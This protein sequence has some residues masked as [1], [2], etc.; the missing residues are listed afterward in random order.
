[1]ATVSCALDVTPTPYGVLTR[2]LGE[3]R[4]YAET[5]DVV[6]VREHPSLIRQKYLRGLYQKAKRLLQRM[7][8][9]K[10][11]RFDMYSARMSALEHTRPLR[12]KRNIL[13]DAL[14]WVTGTA[15]L[16]DIKAVREKVNELMTVRDSERVIIEDTVA[17]VKENRETIDEIT[18]KSNELIDI[19][20]RVQGTLTKL[21][22]ATTRLSINMY[23]DDVALAIEN[24]LSYLEYYKIEQDRF[25][26]MFQYRRDLAIVGHLTEA[27]VNRK[28]IEI[29]L[30]KV[31]TDLT[32][33]YLYENMHVRI[34]NLERQKLGFWVSIPVLSRESY[35]AWDIFAVPFLYRDVGKVRQIVPELSHAGVGLNSGKIITLD[36]CQ[37]GNPSLCPSPVEYGKLECVDGILSK[38]TEKMSKCLMEEVSNYGVRVRRVSSSL[39]LLFTQ[40]ETLEERC[41]L[42][43]VRSKKINPGTYV[44]KANIGCTLASNTGWTFRF[45]STFNDTMQRTDVF[46]LEVSNVDFVLPTMETKV[47]TINVSYIKELAYV[48]HHALP[49]LTKLQTVQMYN[50]S[51]ATIGIT[52]FGLAAA[53][54]VFLSVL[55]Y[56]RNKLVLAKKQT[57]VQLTKVDD[58]KP[59]DSTAVKLLAQV[60][61]IV[62]N[63]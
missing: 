9:I 55:V 38:N 15:T 42:E 35:T 37:Y 48:K 8:Q 56:R 26:Q 4:T 2:R 16:D 57:K 30:D 58:V 41:K 25:D 39:L 6:F 23:A 22:N 10:P 53:V 21:S 17:C 24:I 44:V 60:D 62:K 7:E 54:V 28:D 47:Q 49:D 3:A 29:V 14:R 19:V 12:E 18:G 59:N 11:N 13:G 43:P 46:P 50:V 34:M 20:N 63:P 45:L 32:A 51:G 31:Q 40:G 52:G 27:L 36:N 1:M 33:D 5:Y 61:P